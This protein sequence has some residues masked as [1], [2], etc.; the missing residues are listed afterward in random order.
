MLTQFK[1]SH[2]PHSHIPLDQTA[3]DEGHVYFTPEDG[4][5]YIDSNVNG[6]NKRVRI[7]QQDTVAKQQ[8]ED[9][10]NGDTWLEEVE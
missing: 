2:G 1:I 10:V 7:G 9:M 3:F 4:K 6:E 8:P 5:L